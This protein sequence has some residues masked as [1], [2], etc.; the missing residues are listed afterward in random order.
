MP[1]ARFSLL[2]LALIAALGCSICGAA[3]ERGVI[4]DDFCQKRGFLG[5]RFDR[6]TMTFECRVADAQPSKWQ[7]ME[8]SGGR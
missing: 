3:L 8:P 5:G 6:K 4:A 7:R 2:V 1:G